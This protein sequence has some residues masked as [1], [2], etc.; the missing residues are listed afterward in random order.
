MY[1]DRYTVYGIA[2]D[3]RDA[4]VTYCTTMCTGSVYHTL[5]PLS[6]PTVECRGLG[7][8]AAVP[9][10]HCSSSSSV[11]RC[12]SCDVSPSIV[13]RS[14]I[15]HSVSTLSVLLMLLYAADDMKTDEQ[16]I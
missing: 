7:V 12:G 3:E 10:A 16:T 2:V 13:M 6:V 8:R 15:E 5:H 14:S 11:V 1:G 4:T 9:T